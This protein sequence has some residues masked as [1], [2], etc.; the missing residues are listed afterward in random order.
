M[1]F[2]HT[3]EVLGIP[4]QT[5]AGLVSLGGVVLAWT[6]ITLTLRRFAAWRGR[7]R[8][9]YTEAARSQNATAA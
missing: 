2:A 9:R 3:G 8:A 4:G 1:R 7:Q 6:G 5:L